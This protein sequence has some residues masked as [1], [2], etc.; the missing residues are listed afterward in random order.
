MSVLCAQFERVSNLQNTHFFVTERE[1][2]VVVM[3]SAM[4]P[5]TIEPP[6]TDGK[7]FPVND[8]RRLDSWSLCYSQLT[9]ISDQLIYF[10]VQFGILVQTI[11]AA[12]K[13]LIG[14]DHLQ[15]FLGHASTNHPYYTHLDLALPAVNE[16]LQQAQHHV[17]LYI[18]ET[19]NYS[20]KDALWTLATEQKDLTVEHI[21]RA[22]NHLKESTIGLYDIRLK[23]LQ[24]IHDLQRCYLTTLPIVSSSL[25]L[26][27]CQVEGL[28]CNQDEKINFNINS[29]NE[30]KLQLCENLK[31]NS[32]AADTSTSYLELKEDPAKTEVES[33]ETVTVECDPDVVLRAALASIDD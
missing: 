20:L 3:A 9:N 21:N 18:F 27:E 10:D 31:S 33:A 16:K 17:N 32:T 7:S 19:V 26:V 8:W 6:T 29:L 22:I 4:I 24:D 5:N 12:V 13:D 1:S 2:G 15:P 25:S 14:R 28:Y 30:A 23:I 11:M